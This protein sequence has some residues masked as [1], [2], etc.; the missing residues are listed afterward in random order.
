[1]LCRAD[2]CRDPPSPRDDSPPGRAAPQGPIWQLPSPA[3]AASDRVSPH[4]GQQQG[5]PHD[6]R[7]RRAPNAAAR[8]FQ[9]SPAGH[10]AAPPPWEQ[11]VPQL[12]AD[13]PAHMGAALRPHPAHSLTPRGL[14]RR[15]G[16]VWP[17]ASCSERRAR[18]HRAGAAPL[19]SWRHEEFCSAGL[20]WCGTSAILAAPV[21]PACVT[22]RPQIAGRRCEVAIRGGF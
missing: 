11:A 2:C 21:E 16:A 20:G 19:P 7:L 18:R 13:R 5:H 3:V 1:M 15:P 9:R 10:D 17:P 4:T 6:R 8:R 22:E 14:C 12:K